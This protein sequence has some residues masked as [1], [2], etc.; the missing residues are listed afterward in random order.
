M[1]PRIPQPWPFLLLWAAAC[2]GPAGPSRGRSA[3]EP[4]AGLLV[5]VGGGGV[6]R[7]ALERALAHGGGPEARVVVVP[8]AS[9][10]PRA[11]PRAAGLWTEAEA[12]H[13]VALAEPG[14]E[15]RA[16]I[17]AASVIWFSGGDQARLMAAVEEAGIAS[18]VR[19]RFLAG[20][21]VGGT[22]AGAAAISELMIAGGGGPDRPDRMPELARGLGLLSHAVVDQHFRERRREPRLRAVVCRHPELTGLGI[23]ERTALLVRR[24]QTEILGAGAV[25]VVTASAG[26]LDEA[27]LPAGWS[28]ALPGLADESP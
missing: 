27:I 9:E 28:G 19:A 22:S 15:A 14:P 26:V 1:S 3:P 17:E 23:D 6:P 10:S 18:L 8:W 4:P 2:A 24:G 5:I 25:T 12:Q 13:V 20:A 16:A 11:G 21:V 7:E